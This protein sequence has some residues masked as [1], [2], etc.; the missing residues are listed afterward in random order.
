MLSSL[1]M[2]EDCMVGR[3]A[4]S[5]K[6]MEPR[7]SMQASEALRDM[8]LLGQGGSQGVMSG[9]ELMD[10]KVDSSVEEE[11]N[12]RAAGVILHSTDVSLVAMWFSWARVQSARNI[13]QLLRRAQGV[14]VSAVVHMMV[15]QGKGLVI[16][17]SQGGLH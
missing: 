4:E 8:Q 11:N 3:L 13:M 5:D 12:W 6:R 1:M 17:T 7:L 16:M 10:S 15:K 2:F 9:T 14:R